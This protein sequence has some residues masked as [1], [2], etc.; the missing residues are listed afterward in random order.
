VYFYDEN[1]H[2]ITDPA[3]QAAWVKDH[4][5]LPYGEDPDGLP[6]PVADEPK[7]QQPKV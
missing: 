6:K 3:K 5:E 1:G 2:L 4:P 7:E